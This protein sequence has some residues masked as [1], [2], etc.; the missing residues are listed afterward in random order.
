MK[1]IYGWN[2]IFPKSQKNLLPPVYWGY[3]PNLNTMVKI[4][5]VMQRPRPWRILKFRQVKSWLFIVRIIKCILFYLPNLFIDISKAYLS[6]GKP[7]EISQLKVGGE[8]FLDCYADAYPL[9]H[10]IIWTKDVI[11]FMIYMVFLISKSCRGNT[12]SWVN[13]KKFY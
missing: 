11:L 3:Y 1:N 2:L 6:L 13:Q 9:P 7:F 4:C 8:V 10:K 12:W 5:L